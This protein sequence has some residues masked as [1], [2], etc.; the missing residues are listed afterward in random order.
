[1]KLNLGENIRKYRKAIGLTQEQL[2]DRLGVSC[3]SVSRWECGDGYPDME[4]LPALAGLFGVTYDQLLADEQDDQLTRLQELL[5]SL[6]TAAEQ[7]DDTRVVEYL[8]T[9]CRNM[10]RYREFASELQRVP[11]AIE[12]YNA[13]IPA[14]VLSEFRRYVDELQ[15][16]VPRATI[17]GLALRTL[18]AVEDDEHIDEF[19]QKRT[20]H[21]DLNGEELLRYRYIIRKDSEKLA[22]MNQLHR[23]QLLHKLF[24]DWESWQKSYT[25]ENGRISERYLACLHAL[26]DIVPEPEH[27]VSGD[28]TL[29]L[30]AGIRLELG[31]RKAAYEIHTD[32][33]G[34][35]FVTLEDTVNL[36]EQ[37]MS[38][39]PFT[40]LTCRSPLFPTF[41]VDALIAN[42]AK[43]KE[44]LYIYG[45]LYNWRG[46]IIPG[47]Y[48]KFLEKWTV[49]DPVRDDP[50]FAEL[51]QRV[52]RL[53]IPEEC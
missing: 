1:M 28:G 35:A 40:Q 29:D 22:Y 43:K 14:A 49:F 11:A 50:H 13:E 41:T 52:K 37:F 38:L 24:N 48:L 17:W 42:S 33:I 2:A 16:H 7:R 23:F 47:R 10:I 39:G 15:R 32:R 25:E 3:Q 53:T 4:L 12:R 26:H 19:L 30:W 51:Y 31:F 45:N 18:A 8:R 21:I 5:G 20:A 6:E 36:L 9:I 27:P 46:L 34:N 44:G